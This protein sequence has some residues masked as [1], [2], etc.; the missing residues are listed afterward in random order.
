M[1]AARELEENRKFGLAPL[2]V[3]VVTGQE[4]SPHI[5]HAIAA[6]PWYVDQHRGTTLQHQR[7]QDARPDDQL[8]DAVPTSIIVRQA[9][10]FRPGACENC[11][12]ATHVRRD[13]TE[14]PRKLGARIT[15]ER[16][17]ADVLVVAASPQ[18]ATFEAKHDRWAGADATRA[19]E[20]SAA[21]AAAAG[22]SLATSSALAA[23]SMGPPAPVA[24]PGKKQPGEATEK[25]E[26]S[27]CAIG[28]VSLS[29]GESVM[30]G[31]DLPKY[32]INLDPKSALYD[33]KSRSMRG[34]PH[35]TA[36]GGGAGGRFV[37]SSSTFAG[38]NAKNYSGGYAAYLE[39]QLAALKDPEL[40]GAGPTKVERVLKERQAA[41]EQ[42]TADAKRRL[43]EVYGPAAAAVG[44]QE[45]GSTGGDTSDLK[46]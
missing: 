17:G 4:I 35:L 12:S 11:G 5:P 23:P 16:I 15:G 19:K 39:A 3:D 24:G 34:N 13:C 18:D 44:A 14:R 38:D 46:S 25:D 33:P 36:G 20:L 41:K 22:A 8:L 42:A 10:R 26:H 43:D 1:R 6:V 7:K 21:H 29:G 27:A 2:A 30:G 9:K 37:A 45:G 28:T 40:E 32:L 31:G